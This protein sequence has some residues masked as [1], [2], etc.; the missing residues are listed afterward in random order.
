M[1]HSPLLL[2]ASTPRW[3]LPADWM[4]IAE[5]AGFQMSSADSITVFL[6]GGS[7]QVVKLRLYDERR[8]LRATSVIAA[9]SVL[10]AA[11]SDTGNRYAWERNRLSDLVG[12]SVDRHGRLIGEAWIPLD[13]LLPDE[14]AL[15]LSELARVCDWHEFRLSG[16][17]AY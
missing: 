6:D 1:S 11:F 14:F 2:P 12:F 9:P 13:G 16:V 3:T 8:V 10:A 4:K 5:R 17:D 15:Y 7:K